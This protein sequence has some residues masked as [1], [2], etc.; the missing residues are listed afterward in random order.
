MDFSVSDSPLL[1]PALSLLE[2]CFSLVFCLII[3]IVL[4]F[5]TS[6]SVPLSYPSDTPPKMVMVVN[7][8]VH[9]TKAWMKQKN[10]KENNVEHGIFYFVLKLFFPVILFFNSIYNLNNKRFDKYASAV[11]MF[12]W[13]LRQSYYFKTPCQKIRIGETN[14]VKAEKGVS[15]TIRNSSECLKEKIP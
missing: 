13:Y 6:L 9:Q 15:Y 5:G 7:G 1:C 14:N 10:E 11:L 3:S 2:F 8:D 4:Y 12:W